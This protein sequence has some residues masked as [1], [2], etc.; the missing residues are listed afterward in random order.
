MKK[1]N[2]YYR[3]GVVGLVLNLLLLFILPFAVDPYFA[4]IFS[5]LVPIWIILLVV[6]WRKE[7]PRR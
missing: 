2:I 7:H 1:W 3:I 4:S 6:G 5:S